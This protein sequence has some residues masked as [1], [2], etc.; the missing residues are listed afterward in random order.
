MVH[1]VNGDI[2]NVKTTRNKIAD[3]KCQGHVYIKWEYWSNM[4]KIK[5]YLRHEN[6]LN[7]I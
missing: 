6:K 4:Q 3:R 1:V 7:E 2:V 5:H